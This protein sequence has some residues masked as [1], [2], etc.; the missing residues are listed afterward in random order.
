MT[1][2][3][4]VTRHMPSRKR[5]LDRN[6]L[7]LSG[8]TCKDF[9]QT[10]I[11]DHE[12]IGIDRAGELLAKH[13]PNADYVW[14]LDDDDMIANERV[15]ERMV[16]KLQERRPELMFVRFDHR[17]AVLPIPWAGRPVRSSIGGSS[18]V[19]SAAIWRQCRDA[20]M[21]RAYEHDWAYVDM[22][23]HVADKIT[24]L[25]IVAARLDGQRHG[26]ET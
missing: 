14:V 2:L 23:W 5:L 21:S 16:A 4:I 1:T 17:Y 9:I 3:E 19:S 24:W 8:Q 7:L 13:T 12:G 15:V 22:A 10:V 18:V 26:S 11:V 6:Q 20:W 25:D